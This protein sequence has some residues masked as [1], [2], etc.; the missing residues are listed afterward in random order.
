MHVSADAQEAEQLVAV[1]CIGVCIA[2]KSGTMSINEA[3]NCLFSPY[4]ISVLEQSGL[5]ECAIELI[6]MGTELEDV[7]SL[8]PDKLSD[9]IDELKNK[10]IGLLKA[11]PPRA[12]PR[13]RWVKSG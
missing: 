9:A 1:L 5:S 3:E 4:T 7:E 2:L 6:H 11:L 13:D 8:A 10:A 12:L